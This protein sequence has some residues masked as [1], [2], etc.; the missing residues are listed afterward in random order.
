MKE[1]YSDK[2]VRGKILKARKFW[3][4]EILNKRKNVGN[5]NCFLFNI[6][7]HPVL[8][9]LKSVL[10]EIHLL[11]TPDREHGKLFERIPIVV[12][13]RAKSLKNILV[14]AKVEH[15]KKRKTCG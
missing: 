4:S 1:S 7:Y 15:L 12:F 11:L 8:S 6:T 9:K 5:K 3:R 10:S 13:R 2:M 14:R